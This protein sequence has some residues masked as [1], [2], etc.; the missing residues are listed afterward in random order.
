M[1]DRDVEDAKKSEIKLVMKIMMC[2]IKHTLDKIEC[3]IYY[4]KN[5]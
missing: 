5:N 4:R 2:E 3:I 1:L